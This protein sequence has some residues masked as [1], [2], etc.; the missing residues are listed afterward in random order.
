MN[1][2]ALTLLVLLALLGLA[3][4]AVAAETPEVKPP[5]PTTIT[6]RGVWNV[7][8]FDVSPPLRSITPIPPTLVEHTPKENRWSGL[9]G[10]LGPQDTDAV[11][12]TEVGPGE[13]PA[14][15]V[16]FA[17]PAN[18]SGVSPPD[19]IGD[20]GP[21]HYVFMSN[22]SFQI[23][24]KTGT[25]LYGPALNNT[26]WAGFG[27]P[28]Q[29]ENAG[30][31]VVLHDQIADRWMLSQFTANGPTYYN[32]VAVSTTADPTGSY[33]RWAFT[34]GANFPDYPKYGFWPDGLYIS[35]REFNSGGS[36][37]GVGAYAVDR[38]QL[39]AGTPA[40]TVISFLITPGSAAYNVGDGLLP[41]DMDGSTPP[42]A[43][44]PNYYLGSMDNGGP[45]AAP[46]DALNLFKFHAD[47][48]TPANST[49]TGPTVIPISAY[50]TMLSICSGRAC[51]P[52]PGTTN[53][54]DHLGYR[55]RPLHRLAYRNYGTHESLV[56]NQSVEGSTGMSGVRWW[57]VRS[58]NTA[59]VLYQEGTYNPGATDG[60]HRWMGSI[61]MDYV[62]NMALGYS[63]SNGTAPNYP[64]LWYTGRL[65]GDP[66]GSMPQGEASIFNGTGSFTGS[67]R[68]GD[69][70]SMNV[71]PTDDCT[72]WY[73][74][75]YN[76]VT[77][78]NWILHVGAFKFPD[79]A[80][81]PSFTVAVTPATQAI[82]TPTDAVYTVN[83]G[84]IMGFS[85]PVTLS[86][87][88]NPAGTTVAFSTNP[89]TPAGTST[90]TISGTGAAAAGSY[91]VNVQ[92]Q[93]AGPITKDQNVTLDVYT[94]A[95]GTAALLTPADGALNQPATPSFTW[96]PFPQ[97]ATYVLEVAT[98]AGFTAIVHTSP[99]LTTPAY[100]GATLN[101]NTTYYW[102]VRATNTCGTGLDSGVFSFTTQAAPGDC[103]AGTSAN[104]LFTD[105]FE[106]GLGAWTHSGTGDTWAITTTPSYV[107][108]GTQAMHATDPAVVSDQRLVSPAVVLPVGQN[109]IT[110][111]F[112]NFQTLEHRTAGGCYDGG[113]LEVSTN[114]GTTW[115]QVPTVNLLTDPY[116]G[117]ITATSNPMNGLQAWCGDPQPYLNSIADISSYA[118]QTVNFRFR[119]G[120]DSSVG[121]PDGW[122]IDDVVVQSCLVV[123]VE[124][125]SFNV[126]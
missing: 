98:T 56:T 16:H 97:A 1:R 62:G 65:A 89:V 18:V 126:Q 100:S 39:M 15:S 11:A 67:N 124:L 59:P 117:A 26:L 106:S 103:G 78:S 33:Y 30:D 70:S 95:P 58:P 116:D 55:Q 101:T 64:S 24:N 49:F 81:A 60:I 120:S 13:I 31:P 63:A 94:G 14:P 53:A 35:T 75:Q 41:S 88:G 93:S 9:E 6:Y 29:T 52:Q 80:M 28:C 54:V 99:T 51:I 72:F 123:P 25:S 7:V 109:P 113:I 69:Y 96:T 111:K 108:S 114:G 57:E 12:Q 92:G 79:C 8:Q 46:Q 34:T 104:V 2:K 87:T 23:F 43:G 37:V 19:S 44:S 76:A 112:W 61:A 102:R 84:S 27:G 77:G 17:G 90:M 118:G 42:P 66:L 22:L 122:N 4:A 3:Q 40:P 68:W 21:N 85:S 50:D 121:R 91:T 36:F 119:M 74:N 73:V 48:A 115:T 110:L 47:F 82:C 83:V 105:G 5:E 125:Q 107:H 20:V 10:E 86:A 32:C 45:Y 38:T 71:D